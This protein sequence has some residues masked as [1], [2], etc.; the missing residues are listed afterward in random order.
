MPSIKRIIVGEDEPE[1]RNYLEMALRCQGYSVDVAQ[2]GEE[3]LRLLR[4]LNGQAGAVLLD[5]IMPRKDG[6]E[7]LLEIRA[8]YRDVPVIMISGESSPSAVVN[9]MKAGATDFI[10]KPFR[11]GDLIAALQKV[12]ATDA[13]PYA[14]ETAAIAAPAQ[15]YFGETPRIREIR[16]TIRQISWSDAPVLIQGETGAG[17]EVMAR[18]IHAHSRRGS[19]PFLKLNCAALPSE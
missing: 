18:E 2:D 8:R 17:K 11:P 1:V 3:V 16:S 12:I 15:T 4:N 14:P 5:A 9:A 19:K 6:I 7:T 13:G 10:V